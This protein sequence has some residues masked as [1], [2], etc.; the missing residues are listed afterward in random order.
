MSQNAPLP[1]SRL[2]AVAEL[3]ARAGGAELLSWRG[4]FT[5][6]E[7][8]ARDFVTDAD[9]AS[10]KAVAATIAE[11]FPEHGVVGEESPAGAAWDSEFCWVVDPL[12]GTTNYLHGYPFYAVSVAATRRGKLL[13]G[14]VY[15]PEREECFTAAA[16]EGASLNGQ[17]MAASQAA[18]VADALIA[19]SLPAD[20]ST[21]SPDFQRLIT[22]TPLCQAI[23]RTGSA[24]LNLAYVACGRFDAHWA[25]EIFPWD[26]AAGVLLIQEAGGAVTASDGEP[27]DVRRADYLTASTAE[28]H[29]ALLPLMRR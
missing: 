24:A 15:D 4:R 19:I 2:L 23:R 29:A 1:N 8:G 5:A 28:L 25:H 22:L 16:G 6:R 18:R 9:L 11:H 17:P 12:D 21:K 14:A 7:K 27:F 13:A 20:V 3:A 10:Q 26:A